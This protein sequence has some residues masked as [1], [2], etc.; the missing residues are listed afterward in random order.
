MSMYELDTIT[1]QKLDYIFKTYS[2]FDKAKKVGYV[3]KPPPKGRLNTVNNNMKKT[4]IEREIVS[5]MNK[6]NKNNY[7]KLQNVL[8]N[9]LLTPDNSGVVMPLILKSVTTNTLYIGMISKLLKSIG[10]VD[11]KPYLIAFIESVEGCVSDPDTI[12][13]LKATEGYDGFCTSNKLKTRIIINIKFCMLLK[14][15]FPELEQKIQG[16]TDAITHVLLT[17][18]HDVF[19]DIVMQSNVVP[20]EQLMVMYENNGWEAT[21]SPRMK[22]LLSLV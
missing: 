19:I 18:C 10:T 1:T 20:H 8:V 16:L 12:V 22:I 7:V 14:F 21:L 11:V 13:V 9:K 5:M 6:M 2:C 17:D 3:K 4:T 15:D